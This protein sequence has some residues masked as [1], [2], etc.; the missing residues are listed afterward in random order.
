M[1]ELEYTIQGQERRGHGHGK[2]QEKRRQERESGGE[3]KKREKKEG[4]GER[5]GE[6]LGQETF[7]TELSLPK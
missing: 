6:I 4:V 2:K 5:E 3:K 7:K 1:R